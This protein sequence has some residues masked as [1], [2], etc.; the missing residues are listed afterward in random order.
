MSTMIPNSVSLG[1]NKGRIIYPGQSIC[2]F[3][4]WSAGGAAALATK[5]GTARQ[6]V[7]AA[8]VV[9]MATPS[10]AVRTPMSTKQESSNSSLVLRQRPSSSSLAASQSSISCSPSPRPCSS[11]MYLFLPNS[12]MP[13][14]L[15]SSEVL[16][17]SIC[18]LQMNLL[19][20]WSYVP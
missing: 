5:P 8:C 15:F 3:P 11:K 17:S 18:P 1:P 6:R 9:K 2:C 20:Q 13:I 10:L 12:S 14:S 7:C 4:A 19:L 16:G